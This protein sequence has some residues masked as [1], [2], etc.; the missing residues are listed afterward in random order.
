MVAGYIIL[1]TVAALIY[2]GVGQRIL[3][4]LGL[5][6]KTALGFIVAM[7]IGTFINIPLSGGNHPLVLNLGGLILIGLALYVLA[8]ASGKEITRTILGIVITTGIIYAISKSFTFE[9]GSTPLDPTYLWSIIAASVAYII[10]RSRR[11]AFVSAVLSIAL[12]DFINYFLMV[13]EGATGTTHI[14]GAGILDAGLIAGFLAVAIAEIVGEAR[15]RM[16]GGHKQENKVNLENAEYATAF[17]DF[18]DLRD[19]EEI[20]RESTH[21]SLALYNEKNIKRGDRRG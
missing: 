4:R 13:G 7:I 2:L 12:M 3:D 16:A 5:T 10:G 9:E 17:L 21:F 15:E 18:E 8:K 20:T 6:D 14:G 11:A 19:F 1:L